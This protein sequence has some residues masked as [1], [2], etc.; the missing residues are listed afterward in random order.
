MES[1]YEV[2]RY[3]AD[4][5]DI[6]YSFLHSARFL[7]VYKRYEKLKN[8]SF[9]DVERIETYF[10]PELEKILEAQGVPE[11]FLFM[12]MA[13]SNFVSHAKSSKAAVGI[14][15]FMP[16]TAR[17]YGLRIDRYVDERKDPI[18]STN[19]AVKYL[20]F[21]YQMFG[22]WYLAAL[23][24]NAGEGTVIRAIKRAGTDDPSVLLDP[25][26]KYLPKESRLYLY[27][28]LSFAK[29]SYDF[30]SKM[31]QEL[32][33]ILA[34]SDDYQV[35]PV[36]VAGGERL[37]SIAELIRLKLSHLKS[38]NPHLRRG[39]TP[40]DVK[41]YTI[42]L[43]RF[44]YLAFKKAYREKKKRRVARGSS[45]L[46]HEVKKGE[47]LYAIA[48]RYDVSIGA[49]KR[50]NRLSGSLLR[51]GQK[52]KIPIRRKKIYYV[53]RPGDTIIK[54]ARRFRIDP[55]KLKKWNDKKDNLIKVGEKLVVIY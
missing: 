5:L 29:L 35:I 1:D 23:A 3:I 12:A 54:I 24:Y 51:A 13:E 7:G 18:K 22:K 44:K 19:A 6:P 49:I 42:Y 50:A 25:K 36:H 16:K 39:I 26:K 4:S 45:Y 20:K 48:K 15:Q 11:I 30:D 53:V 43:P 32:G 47:S 41:R 10:I 40:P 8:R 21:L 55:K 31:S 9:I 17:K 38:L 52:L 28:I 14:W 46:V 27:K 37:A 33:Y 2:D 34:R